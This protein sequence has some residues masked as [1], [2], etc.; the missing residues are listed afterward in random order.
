M[1]LS[2]DYSLGSSRGSYD[3][4]IYVPTY[5]SSLLPHLIRSSSRSVARRLS[6]MN[7]D[8]VYY[9]LE[10]KMSFF[11][12]QC[13]LTTSSDMFW[14]NHQW[15]RC[16]RL[17]P[18][19]TDLICSLY[20]VDYYFLCHIYRTHITHIHHNI[21]TSNDPLEPENNPLTTHI[22]CFQSQYQSTDVP[23]NWS[24]RSSRSPMVALMSDKTLPWTA[25]GDQL[26]CHKQG[27][28]TKWRALYLCNHRWPGRASWSVHTSVLW[29]WGWK[30]QMCVV[31]G[32]FSGSFQRIVCMIVRR[33]KKR[34]ILMGVMSDFIG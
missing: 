26:W 4:K 20:G 12:C 14:C 29:Y 9:I 27:N 32:L 23:M 17:I 16:L 10:E 24:R 5:L 30:Q 28:E 3:R 21:I 11:F 19:R 15:Y 13:Q 25:P 1:W 2:G 7:S 22:C 34:R 18:D 6:D 33:K 8:N 31:R